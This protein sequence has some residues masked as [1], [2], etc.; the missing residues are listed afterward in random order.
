MEIQHSHWKQQFKK[1]LKSCCL[2]MKGKLEKKT[3]TLSVQI[4]LASNSEDHVE[5]STYKHRG[6][7][8]E[9]EVF[10]LLSDSPWWSNI[11][12]RNI[13]K[14]EKQ[15][16]LWIIWHWHN[17]KKQNSS[18]LNASWISNAN[19]SFSSRISSKSTYAFVF[20][21]CWKMYCEHHICKNRLSEYDRV[22]ISTCHTTYLAIC[23]YKL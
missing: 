2:C 8:P 14:T 7:H 9:G 5:C 17:K 18:V 21:Q 4:C 6:H 1:L 20:L 3:P 16:F 15:E 12:H 13:C 10:L 22:I 23:E 11:R 19:Q